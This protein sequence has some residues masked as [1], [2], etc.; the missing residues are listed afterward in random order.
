MSADKEMTDDRLK[1][2]PKALLKMFV[3]LGCK[4]QKELE[5]R[6]NNLKK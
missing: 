1:F 5:R 2:Q 4:A 3:E 6:K